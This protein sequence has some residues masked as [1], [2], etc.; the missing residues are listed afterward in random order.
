ML[1]A[2]FS[3]RHIPVIDLLPAFLADPRCPLYMNNTHWNPAGHVL[4]AETIA[5]AL[6]RWIS[7]Q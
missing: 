5:P 3:E 7:A 4:A 2:L 6:Q 1:S